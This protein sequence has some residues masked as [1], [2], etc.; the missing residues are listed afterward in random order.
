M[1]PTASAANRLHILRLEWLR[2]KLLQIGVAD[3][4]IHAPASHAQVRL[5]QVQ[6][7]LQDHE[8]H[9]KEAESEHTQPV[10]AVDTQSKQ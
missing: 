5:S 9:D 8:Q 6:G 7:S 2:S 1:D 3:P 10:A 4:E